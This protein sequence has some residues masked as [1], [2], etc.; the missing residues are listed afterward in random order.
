MLNH[1][2]R[3]MLTTSSLTK[4]LSVFVIA[5]MLFAL[6]GC[7][8]QENTANS[9]ATTQVTT[10]ATTVA[11]TE[12]TTVAPVT[13]PDV[14]DVPQ[15]SQVQAEEYTTEEHEDIN[16]PDDPEQ[17]IDDGY[18]HEDPEPTSDQGRINAEQ[19]LAQIQQA[20]A[21]YDWTITSYPLGYGSGIYEGNYYIYVCLEI[22]CGSDGEPHRFDGAVHGTIGTATY[23]SE[24][25]SSASPDAISI[26]V[27]DLDRSLDTILN[28]LATYGVPQ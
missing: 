14:S 16:D 8:E 9:E 4:V 25:R 18:W 17:P 13:V 2:K 23:W 12:A 3:G 21:S 11:T 10:Q 22:S 24:R 20:A 6:T 7:D 28:N 1:K 15:N 27:L 26:D 5:C 19:G